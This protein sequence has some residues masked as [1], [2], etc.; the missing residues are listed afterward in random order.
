MV[1]KLARKPQGR[2]DA[3]EAARVRGDVAPQGAPARAP[4][5]PAGRVV[6][7][8]LGRHAQGLGHVLH[9]ARPRRADGPAHAAAARLRPAHEA[10]RHARPRRACRP[11]GRPRRPRRSSPS[12]SATRPAAPAPSR[13]RR[14]ASSPMRS[15][16]R[17]T[18]TTASARRRRTS[19]G[20]DRLLQLGRHGGAPEERLGRRAAAVPARR[21]ALRAAPQGRS[22]AATSSS[23]AS[24]ASTS[25]RWPSSCAACAL[26]RDDGPHAAVL[27][28]RP[29]DQVRQQPGRR[30][31]RPVP[32]LPGHGLEEPRGRRQEPHQRR[33]LRARTRATK[34]IK[35]FVKDA[36]TPDLR[37]VPRRAERSSP[38]T[39][40]TQ[41]ATV[42]D[43]A[44]AALAR[45]HELPVHDAAER[46][47]IYREELLG[48]PA[49]RSLKAAMDLW[50][51]CWFWPADELEDAPL[52]TTFAA[53]PEAT[54]ARRRA[55]RGREALLPL[56][57]RVPRRLPRCA[58]RASTPCSGNPPWD[59]AKPNSKEFFS[60]IDP[61]YRSYGKQEALRVSDASYFADAGCRT[62]VARLQRRLPRRSRTSWATPRARSAIPQRD[63]TSQRPL[64]DR[65]A[66]RENEALHDRW[67][68]A[69]AQEPAA[70]PTRRIPSAIRA[71]PTSTSTSSSSSRRTRCCGPAGGLASS[72]PRASTP[73]TGTGGLRELFLDHCRWE[74]LFGFENRDGDL[75][76]PPLASSSTRSSFEKGGRTTAIR[77]A[78]MRRALEDWERAEELVPPLRA[79]AGRALQPAVAGHPR[80]PVASGTSRSSRR[81][82]RNSVLLGDDGPDGWGIKYATRV[83]HDE[84]LEA[85]PAAAEVGGARLPARRV[86]PLAQGRL[87]A[88]RRTVGRAG[89]RSGA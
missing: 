89:R 72:C 21:P 79:R 46:A 28:P 13:S 65:S 67:R 10:G 63:E 44:L 59:I 14:C 32:A 30:L 51:A 25:T 17:S 74:W 2:A 50:C 45:L 6:P 68:E 66:A 29:Q 52:P 75:R 16:P 87:A 81:S 47:R 71:R 23:A 36:L 43:D 80:D 53:P 3:G 57:A 86:Q 26:D 54:R 24:T 83:R 27:V 38:R 73:T 56:G 37:H 18:T 15:T 35:A 70:S 61:L 19:A 58:A 7:G 1:G 9:A 20:R 85:L 62:G 88:D 34:A 4:R 31:V 41:A 42:H 49:Y 60:N 64:R 78:F 76:H 84:R 40:R 33:A 39:C 77:T 48:S 12:R 5:R 82:T 8:A 22:C 11:R 55:D 69:R